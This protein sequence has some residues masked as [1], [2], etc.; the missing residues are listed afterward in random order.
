MSDF[1]SLHENPDPAAPFPVDDR[2]RVPLSWFAGAS[3][4][5]DAVFDLFDRGRMLPADSLSIE[6]AWTFWEEM[7]TYRLVKHPVRRFEEP[8]KEDSPSHPDDPDS[9]V[10][11]DWG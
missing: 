3:V 5:P 10:T 4:D 9:W 6:D 1:S 8:P 2:G 11:F 7:I